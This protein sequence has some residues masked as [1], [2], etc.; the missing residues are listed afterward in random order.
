MLVGAGCRDI[1]HSALGHDFAL[2]ATRDIDLGLAIASWTTYDRLTSNLRPIDSTGIR[3]TI[4]DV[5][6]DLIPFGGIEIPPGTATPASRKEP[7]NVWGFNE[8]FRAAHSLPLPHA[9]AIR[10][11]TIAGYTALK[12]EAWLD[13]SAFGDYRDASDIATAMYWYLHSSDI[14]DFLY[15]TP[16]GQ[17]LLQ[18]EE[19]DERAAAARA[20]GQDVI[21]L[22][23]PDRHIELAHRWPSPRADI[24]YNQ[25]TVVNAPDWPSDPHRRQQL[26]EA[27]QR[28]LNI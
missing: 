25:M 14:A 12:L 11:P 20:L 27:F 22:I 19:L 13:R 21:S 16:A 1:L 6:V 10:I 23:G 2:R 26:A 8:A 18:S 15:E 7:I 4:A 9:G 28:G 3:Y 24:F 5:P 17:L